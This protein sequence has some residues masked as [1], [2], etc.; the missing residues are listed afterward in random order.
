MYRAA[1]AFA[2][3]EAGYLSTG[4][5]GWAEISWPRPCG[6]AVRTAPAVQQ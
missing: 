5:I 4:Q 2:G 6:M 3:H 1:V